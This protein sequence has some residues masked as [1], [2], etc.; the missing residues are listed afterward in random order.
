M[1]TSVHVPQGFFGATAAIQ[2]HNSGADPEG[3]GGG[4]GGWGM[5]G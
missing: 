4:G 2:G 5:G 1:H 3:G